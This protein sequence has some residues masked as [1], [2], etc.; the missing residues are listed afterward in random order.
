MMRTLWFTAAT[1]L[2]VLATN[3]AQA[4][5][6]GRPYALALSGRIIDG[7]GGAPIPEG[8]VVAIDGVI[9]CVGR[10]DDCPAPP[11]AALIDAG[12]GSIIP[13]LIDLHAHPR[14]HYYGW[15]LAAGVTTVRSANTDLATVHALQALPAPQSRLIWAGPMLDGGNSAIKRFYPAAEPGAPS[16]ARPA[17]GLSLEGVELLI[18]ETPEQAIA[19]VDALAAE[20]ADWVKLYEQLPPDAFAAA[21]Q[22]AKALGLPTMADLGMA[23]TRGLK[24]AQVDLLEAAALG[25]DSL[26]HASGAALA[27]QRLGGDL[28]TDILDPALIDQLARALLTGKTALVPTLSVSHFTAEPASPE[29]V[30]SELPLGAAQGAVRDGLDQQWRAIHQHFHSA[31][32]NNAKARMDSRIGA[33]VMVRLAQLGG[34]IGAGSDTPAGAYNLPGGGLHLELELMTRA[35]LSPLQALS[36][37]TGSAADILQRKDIGLIAVGRRADLLVVDGDPSQDIRATRRLRQIVLDGRILDPAATEIR[38]LD[39]GEAL[40]AALMAKQAD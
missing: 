1:A 22:R 12:D 5:E 26:E 11:G 15:F 7:A 24:G 27:Y 25:V 34:R 29:P 4:D 39:D 32:E 6:A 17:D 14:A 16:P 10:A 38:A 18:A 9:T 21:V 8:R 31:A 40:L 33:A 28:E 20:G 37:A 19:A 36:A 13:G 35:G 3:P 23:S 2:A 30:L